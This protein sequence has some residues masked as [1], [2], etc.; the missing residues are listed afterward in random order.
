[1]ALHPAQSEVRSSGW[2]NI[3][4]GK[5][6]PLKAPFPYFGGE[7]PGGGCRVELSG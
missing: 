2:S 6:E 4:D 5:A 3:P 1:M 7:G